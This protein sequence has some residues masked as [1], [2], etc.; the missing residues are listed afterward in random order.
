MIEGKPI[1]FHI[2]LS[3]LTKIEDWFKDGTTI[4]KTLRNGTG[5]NPYTDSTV[6][7]RIEL[8]VNDTIIYTN[9]PE[10]EPSFDEKAE[11]VKY[12][13]YT[14]EDVKKKFLRIQEDGKK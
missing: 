14:S 6:T 11:K 9:Y 5:R 12:D 2:E 4:I 7:F 8:K 13:F 1:T 10:Y 3:R